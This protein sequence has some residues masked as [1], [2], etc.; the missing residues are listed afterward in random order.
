VENLALVGRKDEARAL[1]E[2]LLALRN[3]VGLLPEEYDV[4]GECF[5]GNFPQTLTHT[6]L[7]HA[8]ATLADG[9]GD[10]IAE[11]LG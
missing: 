9:D 8:A 1:F 5:L 10:S 3:D 2:R 7:V 6:S 4:S 11:S